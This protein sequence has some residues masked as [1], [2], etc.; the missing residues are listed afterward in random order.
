MLGITKASVWKRISAFLLDFII[1]SI[2]AAGA[3]FLVSTITGY[4]E[5]S[6]QLQKY[7][8]Y[9]E[10]TYAVKF[11]ISLDDYNAL[12]DEEKANYD[13]AYEALV[14]DKDVTKTFNL[15]IMLTI[16]ITSIGILIAVIVTEFVI[17]LI[18]KNG[19]T[20]GKKVF[21]LCLCTTDAVKI[22]SVSLFIRSILGKYTI[23]IMIPV[24][25]IIM[26]YFNTIGIV[27]IIV[28]SL[29]VVIEVVLYIVK[30]G[31]LLHDLMANTLV[32]DMASTRMFD[33]QQD[34]ID[35]VKKKAAEEAEREKY[36]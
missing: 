33:T 14:E 26:I 31:Q 32:V 30:K 17:P 21:G 5:K 13:E 1:L 35:F 34:M 25:L 12:S 23:E 24:L 2:I 20:V 8:T 9:Y 11:D 36:I 7:Y 27:G 29:I 3:A 15:V 16:L 19:Q 6:E 28:L 22:S 10:D 18:L 4:N